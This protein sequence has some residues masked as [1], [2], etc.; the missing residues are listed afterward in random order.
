MISECATA[1]YYP[2]DYLCA[3]RQ[4]LKDYIVEKEEPV[5]LRDKK[6]KHTIE[7]RSIKANDDSDRFFEVYS[8]AKSLKGSATDLRYVGICA[9]TL[10]PKKIRS[11]PKC[12]QK[13]QTTRIEKLT[14][15]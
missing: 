8:E 3:S 4:R 11:P 12:S 15:V 14:P 5:V 6:D 13:N 7:L 9:E 10:R 1:R 2:F